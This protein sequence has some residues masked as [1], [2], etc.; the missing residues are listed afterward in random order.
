MKSRNIPKTT[1]NHNLRQL[2]LVGVLA[3]VLCI[4]GPMVLPLPFSPIPLSLATLA[5]YF[6]SYILGARRGVIC[7]GIYLL[8]GLAGIPVFSGF[9]GGIG[10]VLG[11]TGG[12]LIGYLFMALI[13]GL[14]VD[15]WSGK[16]FIHF[17]GFLLGTAVCYLFGTAWLS[18]QSG[19]TLGAAL[20]VGV[21]PFLPGDL[22]KVIV[23]IT[24]GKQVRKRLVHLQFENG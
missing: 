7:C 17:I 19:L 21:L 24:I 23:G 1:S 10:K 14:F 13:C 2:A 16:T 15:K 5:I 12:Y 3:A 9:S 18:M 22:V 20:A 6:A 4:L 8:M 11:P